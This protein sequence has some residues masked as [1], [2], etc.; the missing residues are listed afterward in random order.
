M[1]GYSPGQEDRRVFE[2]TEGSA[3]PA[4][5]PNPNRVSCP[6]TDVIRTVAF[7]KMERSRAKQWDSLLMECSPCF[8]EYVTFRGQSFAST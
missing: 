6:G 4:A 1:A 3:F 7:R 8:V 5:F 2:A